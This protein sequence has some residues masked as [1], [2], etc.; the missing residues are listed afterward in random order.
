MDARFPHHVCRL[1]R[2]L[3]RLK[4]TPCAWFQ[5]FKLFSECF[6]SSQC[7]LS[8]F[9]Y[10]HGDEVAYLLIY[11]VDI[12]LTTSS[13]DLL[14]HIISSICK[15]FD[16]TDLGTFNFFWTSITR[17]STGMFLSQK[18]YAFKLLDRAPMATCNPT[19]TPSESG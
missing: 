11:I 5:C 4:Q 13:T 8:L 12:I 15:E 6:S 10:R 3:C 14:E 7:D 9:I 2:S 18:K 1:Q 17:D 16:M 19:R